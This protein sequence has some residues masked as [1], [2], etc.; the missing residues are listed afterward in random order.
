MRR[1]S[2]EL[3]VHLIT[4][5]TSQV[6]AARVEEQGVQV[7]AGA[8]DRRGLAG[9]QLA[10][11]FQQAFLGV[12]GDVLFERSVDLRLGIAE[13][14]LDLLIGGQAQGTD[15]GRDR[16]LAVLIDADI[17]NVLGVG[18]VLQP[19]TA[20]GVHGGGEQ[21]LAGTVLAGAVEH[22]GRTNQLGNDC[23]LGTIGD[24][25][26]GIGHEREV[27]HED[28]L[29]LDLAGLLIEQTGSDVQGRCIRSVPFLT[30]FNGI[31]GGFVQAVVHKLQHE[32]AGIVLDSGNIVEDFVQTFLQEPVVRVFLDLDQI[33]HAN[34]F[35]DAGKAHA[36]RSAVLYGLDLYHKTRPLLFRR[37]TK[38]VKAD[39]KELC[40]SDVYSSFFT[41]F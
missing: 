12:M 1:A 20:V 26:A 24:K 13:E 21:V 9:A 7:G 32:I 18:L 40:E 22:A 33:G 29:L 30:F 41:N 31:L 5:E 14:L 38:S 19:G 4:A 39:L 23:T 6:V 8:L 28:L 35:V 25:G 36:G 15:Q 3:V 2:A 16:Q 34:H 37:L 11:D 10:V 17:E 27:A